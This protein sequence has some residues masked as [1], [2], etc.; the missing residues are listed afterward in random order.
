MSEADVATTPFPIP[1]DDLLGLAGVEH[2]RPQVARCLLIDPP[3]EMIDLIADWAIAAVAAKPIRPSAIA[4]AIAIRVS[5]IER[6]RSQRD[7]LVLKLLGGGLPMGAAMTI[8]DNWIDFGSSGTPPARSFQSTIHF[9]NSAD[10]AGDL[11]GILGSGRVRELLYIGRTE[12]TTDVAGGHDRAQLVQHLTLQATIPDHGIQLLKF[13]AS[14]NRPAR[15]ALQPT[16][17]VGTDRWQELAWW[18]DARRSLAVGIR[19]EPRITLWKLAKLP[20]PMGYDE[21]PWILP[22]PA[23]GRL[24]QRLDRH[25]ARLRP[26]DARLGANHDIDPIWL[27]GD[28][29]FEASEAVPFAALKNL[30]GGAEFGRAPDRMI[31]TRDQDSKVRELD[32]MSDALRA[33]VFDRTDQFVGLIRRGA[34]PA[35][36]KWW[37]S[38]WADVPQNSFVAL[39]VF[40]EHGEP[41]VFPAGT[42]TA[43]AILWFEPKLLGVE[44]CAALLTSGPVRDQIRTLSP[45]D[46][47]GRSVLSLDVLAALKLPRRIHPLIEADLVAAYRAGD[48][49]EIS[50]LAGEIY[51][52]NERSLVKFRESDSPSLFG[53]RHI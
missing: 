26:E 6:I 12:W 51:T 32:D 25:Y 52:G 11:I 45:V 20:R 42:V 4:E 19:D 2:A 49:R 13:D 24:F 50:R 41:T 34:I 27:A 5:A 39:P 18:E 17:E 29:G 43:P 9:G 8:A 33:W 28:G 7:R 10:P 14:R 40:E 30:R 48:K 35:H 21:A 53:Q 47:R 3:Q 38:P 46:A 1:F 15:V 44:A 36:E 22:S 31:W 23:I 37:G 16:N